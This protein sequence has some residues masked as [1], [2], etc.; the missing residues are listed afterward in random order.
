MFFRS[1]EGMIH[2]RGGDGARG[3]ESEIERYGEGEGEDN[4]SLGERED[5]GNPN[6]LM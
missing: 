5:A 4:W 1:G 2:E 3:R 6:Y